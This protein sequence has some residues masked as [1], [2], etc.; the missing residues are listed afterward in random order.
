[1]RVSILAPV[2]IL[3]LSTLSAGCNGSPTAPDPELRGGIV[4]TFN[5]SGESFRVWI[6]NPRTIDEVLAL[7][8]GASLA[9][10][11]SGR[12]RTGAGQGGH[13][14]P[15]SWH[16][17]PEDIAMAEVTIEL[18]DGRPSYIEANRDA[19]IREVGRYCPWGAVLQ[20]VEDYR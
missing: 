2:L 17:D 9:G 10:I 13:N 12:L 4:A 18:C 20:Q 15:Y 7:R 3:I 5:V 19:F 8:R 16:L 11:P 1:V 6:T 14:R